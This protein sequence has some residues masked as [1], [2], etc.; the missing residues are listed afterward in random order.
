MLGAAGESTDDAS[1]S[2]KNTNKELR[3]PRRKSELQISF[4]I[5][6]AIYLQV[7]RA[8]LSFAVSLREEGKVDWLETTSGL[9][10][11]PASSGLK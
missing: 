5:D 8:S 9:N 1:V 7:V 11:M 2:A 10:A 4:V 6:I 3:L